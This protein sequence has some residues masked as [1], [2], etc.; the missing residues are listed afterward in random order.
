M[1]IIT[2]TIASGITRDPDTIRFVDRLD[3]DLSHYFEMN[4]DDGLALESELMAELLQS[5][6]ALERMRA[7]VATGQRGQRAQMED[8]K[9][10][11]ERKW[12]EKQ[13]KSE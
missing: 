10:E 12:Q 2:R 13:Q 3:T 1:A 9:K 8:V 11:M 7:Y 4:I 5:G 6:E